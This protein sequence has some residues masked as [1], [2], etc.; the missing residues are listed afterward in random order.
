MADDGISTYMASERDN[1]VGDLL[2]FCYTMSRVSM[3]PSG[4][5]LIN[6]VRQVAS[7]LY[8]G[9]YDPRGPVL[10]NKSQFASK[11]KVY[12]DTFVRLIME[13]DGGAMEGD[14]NEAELKRWSD[15]RDYQME[16]ANAGGFQFQ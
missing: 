13:L 2:R 6:K 16:F 1:V 9:E 5:S 3:E 4:S 12:L 7:T 15:L 8:V 10:K 14:D 11:H